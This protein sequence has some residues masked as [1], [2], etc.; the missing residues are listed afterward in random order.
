MAEQD[1]SEKAHDPTQKRL[2][3]AR[4]KGQIARS[5]DLTSA[6]AL[7]GFVLAFATIGPAALRE[8]GE[9]ARAFLEHPEMQLPLAVS[10]WTI[11]PLLPLLGL[12]AIPVIAFL[13]AQRGLILTPSNL[14]PKLSR[15]DPIAGAGRRFGPEGLAEFLKGTCKLVLVSLAVAWLVSDRVGAMLGSIQL[16]H[17][18]FILFILRLLLDLLIVCL[19][20]GLILGLADLLWQIR[21]HRQ[22]HRM[23]HQELV[24]EHRETEGDPHARA[25]RRQR[26]QEIALNRMMADV[27]KADVVIV[28]PTH[29]A[30]ALVWKRGSGRPPICLAKGTD[31]VAARIRGMAAEHGIPIHLDPPTARAIFATVEIGD[32]IHPEHYRPV[33]AAIR[34]AEAM[35]RKARGR[36]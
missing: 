5:H 19:V 25:E 14:I 33:A 35:R 17:G 10:T 9:A 29:Y 34:F 24:D 32:P 1:D 27:P 7:A 22:R 18:P 4:A 23:S 15:I 30:V 12:P 28:N 13:L 21:L 11:L 20:I 36:R 2:D 31:A 3:D 26:G 16:G 6:V 8:S